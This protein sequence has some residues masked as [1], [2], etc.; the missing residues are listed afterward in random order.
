VSIKENVEITGGAVRLAAQLIR[1][2]APGLHPAVI[3]T[4]GGLEQGAIGAYD[5]AAERLAA[6]GFVTLTIT[7]RAKQGMHDPDDV[8]LALDWLAARP[9]LATRQCGIF[10]HSRGGLA[11]LRAAAHDSR[12][13]SVVAFAALTD[14]RQFVL[15]VKDFAPTRHRMIADWMGGTPQ[16]LPGQYETLSGLR[17]AQRIRQPVLLIQGTADMN[18]PLEQAQRMEQALKDAGNADVRLELV[19]RMGHFCEVGAAGYQFDK[20]AASAAEWFARTLREKS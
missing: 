9:D 5:W 16:E 14:I 1:P 10:G 18:I 15:S 6:A 13:R 2:L 3:L 4:P 8:S 19:E 11:A 7:Y 20:V 17:Q 12:I